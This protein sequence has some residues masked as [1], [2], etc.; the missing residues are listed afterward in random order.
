MAAPGVLSLVAAPQPILTPMGSPSLGVPDFCTFGTAWPPNL[1]K[2]CASYYS[3]STQNPDRNEK[4]AR[5]CLRSATR[6][7]QV[8]TTFPRSTYPTPPPPAEGFWA[9]REGYDPR[10]GTAARTPSV[11][12]G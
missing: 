2:E 5:S 11:R 8:G 3:S 6:Q 10:R 4:G 9:L 1:R 12:E 7:S